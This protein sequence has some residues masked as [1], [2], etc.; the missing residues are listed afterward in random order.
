MAGT[1]VGMFQNRWAAEQAAQALVDKGVP[2]G[3]IT[4]VAKDAGGVD[5]APSIVGDAPLVPGEEPGTE[6]V[7]EVTEHDV[8]QPANTADEAWPR[9]VVGF[10]I[11]ATFG[12]LAVS[13]LI[14]FPGFEPIFAAHPFAPQF[15]GAFIIGVACAIIGAV[16]SDGIPKEAAQAYHND[17]E[18]GRA[19][20]TAMSSSGNAPIMQEVLKESGGKRLGFYTRFI[21]TIQSIESDSMHQMPSE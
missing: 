17:V 12:S 16:T 6:P 4:I 9:A 19:L 13:L 15:L 10:V 7:R 11:G 1:V 5:S 18:S 21:D 2:L 14:Y 3:D 20:V 8:E